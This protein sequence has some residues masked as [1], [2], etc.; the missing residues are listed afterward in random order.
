M[1]TDAVIFAAIVVLL[2]WLIIPRINRDVASRKAER[3][4]AASDAKRRQAAAHLTDFEREILHHAA[5]ADV[6]AKGL[7]LLI[8]DQYIGPWVRAGAHDFQY[9]ANLP[10]QARYVDTFH[11][12]LARNYLDGAGGR[13]Y[14]LTGKGYEA[15]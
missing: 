8:P 10:L 7:V 11:S 4:A 13:V 6:P 15:A 2:G 12:L 1:I 14:R 9:P 3:D 5:S